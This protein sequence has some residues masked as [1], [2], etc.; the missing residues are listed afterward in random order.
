MS[1][2]VVFDKSVSSYLPSTLTP[3]SNPITEDEVSEPETNPGEEEEAVDF[4]P[5][6]ESLISF[7]L[8][9]PNE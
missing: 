6:G 9:R 1:R 3:N 4:G 5:P 8:S 2:D 7:E